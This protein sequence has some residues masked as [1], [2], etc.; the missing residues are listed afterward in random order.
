M[1]SLS[2]VNVTFGGFSYPILIFFAL[3]R[4]FRTSIYSVKAKHDKYMS[5]LQIFYKGMLNNV[6]MAQE[7][8]DQ[9][10]PRLNDLLQINGEKSIII[11]TPD[12]ITV[13]MVT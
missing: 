6:G 9:I 8:V 11:F 1:I 3:L 4:F 13:A 12:K 7:T 10:L 2:C 5:L